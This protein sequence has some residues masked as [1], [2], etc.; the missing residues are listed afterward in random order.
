MKQE[1]KKQ[2]T[3]ENQMSEPG[4]KG[5]LGE[6]GCCSLACDS[7][8][9]GVAPSVAVFFSAIFA[10]GMAVREVDGVLYVMCE[11]FQIRECVCM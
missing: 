2:S 11:S 4:L 3:S 7:G 1:K 9:R 10:L 5:G 8:W 6:V